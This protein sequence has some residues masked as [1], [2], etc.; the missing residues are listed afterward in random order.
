MKTSKHQLGSVLIEGIVAMLIVAIGSVGVIKMQSA[1]INNAAEA[2]TRSEAASLAQAKIDDLRDTMLSN[3]HFATGCTVGNRLTGGSD[4]P[5]GSSHAT[6]T[7]SWAVTPFCNPTRHLVSVTVAW[8]NSTNQSVTLNSVIAWNDP[9]R[10][11][12][13]TGTGGSGGGGFGEPAT[14]RLVN[15]A[16]INALPQGS[17]PLRNDGTA[18]YYSTI[19]QEYSLY[20]S[21]G[22]QFRRVLVSSVE[23]V[24]LSGLIGVENV[25]GFSVDMTKVRIVGSDAVYCTEPLRFGNQNNPSTYGVNGGTRSLSTDKAGAYVCYVPTGWTGTLA[26][27]ERNSNASCGSQL[28]KN[29]KG[30]NCNFT[31]ALACPEL[32]SGSAVLTGERTVKALVLNGNGQVVGQSG[33]LP[34]HNTM[35]MPGYPSLT[36]TQRLD[37]AIY[38]PASGNTPQRCGSIFNTIDAGWSGSVNGVNYNIILRNGAGTNNSGTDGV[39]SIR[40]PDYVIESYSGNGGFAT[41]SGSVGSCTAPLTATG[42]GTFTGKNYICTISGSNYT[43]VVGIGWTGI[44]GTTAITAVPATGSTTNICQ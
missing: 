4:T 28:F 26:L 38:K 43:C 33:V 7:R 34:G 39:P 23:L 29:N 35:Q 13:T 15:E 44:I 19:D 6:Y 9:A 20:V 3:E 5:N 21:V 25:S 22:T 18:T 12:T 31:E 41:V 24:P 27:F 40:H 11:V 8:G 36:R 32:Y 42:T 14:A 17:S 10:E 16:P 37:Y 2:K 30:G 1:L